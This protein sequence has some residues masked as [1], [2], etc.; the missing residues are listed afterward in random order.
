MDLVP[1]Y[2]V[3]LQEKEAKKALKRL[4]CKAKEYLL[5]FS[6]KQ[7][8][9]QGDIYRLLPKQNEID[10]GITENGIIRNL[11]EKQK[12]AYRVVKYL[13]QYFVAYNKQ[14]FNFLDNDTATK[15]YGYKPEIKSYHIRMCLLHLI[16]QT[17]GTAEAEQLTDGA[18]VLCL[19]NMLQR[20]Y[21]V[22]LDSIPSF[23]FLHHPLLRYKNV[24]VGSVHY[25][26]S[27]YPE[28]YAIINNYATEDPYNQLNS[29]QLLNNFAPRLS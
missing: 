24:L 17:Q 25:Y 26:V 28:L 19:L 11:P 1:V 18:L 22:V 21:F 2:R 16:F 9:K 4:H 12:R 7:Y 5:P 23:L 20:L 8:L 3:T 10:T 14:N 13:T 15:L 29:Y 6:F 27:C